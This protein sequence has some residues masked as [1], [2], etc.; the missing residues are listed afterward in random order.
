MRCEND[1]GGG[2]IFVLT[3]MLFGSCVFLLH[4]CRETSLILSSLWPLRFLLI[5]WRATFFHSF[6]FHSQSIFVINDDWVFAAF[7]NYS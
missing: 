5:L 4:F 7:S 1:D 2:A 6:M 3:N